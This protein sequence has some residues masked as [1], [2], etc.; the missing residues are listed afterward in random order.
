MDL[1]CDILLS[2]N[3]TSLEHPRNIWREFNRDRA[4]EA[5]ST[6]IRA[7]LTIWSRYEREEQSL[8]LRMVGKYYLER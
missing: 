6:R 8:K 2:T 5:H 7:N 4:R 3:K 1:R